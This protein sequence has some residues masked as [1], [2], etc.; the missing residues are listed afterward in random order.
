MNFATKAACASTALVAAFIATP[1]MSADMYGGSIKDTGYAPL[2]QVS[3]GA[4]PCY[5]RGDV[6]YGFSNDGNP[7]FDVF[8]QVNDHIRNFDAG[9]NLVSDAIINTQ[10]I[11]V[12]DSFVSG[13]MDNFWFGEVGLGCGSG[14]RGF[15]ADM[16]FGFRQSRDFWGQPQTRTVTDNFEDFGP[17]IVAPGTS[18]TTRS[19][20]DA[21]H[22]SVKSYSLLFN[23]FYDFGNFRGFVPYVGA[24]IGASYN[25]VDDVNAAWLQ[26]SIE[27]D[28]KL[29]LAWQVST[30]VGYQIRENMILDIGYRYL[31]LGDA[32]SGRID[33][34]YGQF[35]V[36]PPIRFEDLTSHEIKVGL[37]YH[38]GSRGGD[39]CTSLK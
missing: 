7:G 3:R 27:G 5:V 17:T 24:G 39:C 16:T 15:R 8:D 29:S 20:S 36:N 19:D 13:D 11:F 2:P 31:D 37:R 38:F 26:D 1:A 10:D 14:S 28:K 4:G 34:S 33:E 9:G 25:I 12:G 22:T 30:G 35:N 6:G 23:G 21:F 32:R 18:Q